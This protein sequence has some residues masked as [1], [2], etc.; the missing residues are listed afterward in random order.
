MQDLPLKKKLERLEWNNQQELTIDLH[1][2]RMQGIMA[3]VENIL[4]GVHEDCGDILISVHW[5]SAH[6]RRDPPA[7]CRVSVHKCTPATAWDQLQKKPGHAC[8]PVTVKHGGTPA[9]AWEQL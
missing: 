5:I 3:D 7:G 1:M 8:D 2:K 9:T 6:H 4:I